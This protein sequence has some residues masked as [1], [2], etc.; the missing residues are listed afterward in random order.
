MSRPAVL[1]LVVLMA[2]GCAYFNTFYNAR[3][4]YDEALRAA[5]QNPDN[6]SAAEAEKLREA[7]EGAGKVLSFYPGSRWADD[8]QLLIGDALLLLGRRSVTGSGTSSFED[9]MRAYSSAIVMTDDPGIRERA[10]LG[11][12]R[13]AMELGRYTDA[14]ASFG[15]VGD[16]ERDIRTAARLGL[17]EA[18]TLDG[19]SL[20]ALAVLDSLGD[21]GLSDSLRGEVWIARG[22]ALLGMGLP[23]SAASASLE[24]SR[25]LRRGQ[26]LYRAVTGAAEALLEAGRPGEAAAVLAPLRTSYSSSRELAAISLLS[27]RASEAA[28]DD[29]GAL[30][31]WEDAA[32]LD[33]SREVG[34]EALWRRALLLEEL[35][36]TEEAVGALGELSSRSGDHVWIR[37]AADRKA[38]LDLLATYTDSLPLADP[39][40]RDLLRLL[41]AE[42][43]L[44]LY[45]EAPGISGE[46][47]TLA[48]SADP[49]TAS[50]ALV[51]MAERFTDDPDSAGAMLMEAL[52]LADSGDLAGRIELQLGLP[53]G[54]AAA[55]RPSALLERAW[56]L[57][58]EGSFAEAWET[59]SSALRSRWSL[60]AEA[61]LLWVAYL[62][63]EAAQMDDSLVEGY[64]AALVRDH[65]GTDEAAAA[66]LRLGRTGGEGGGG[67]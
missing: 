42:K 2:S 67:E 48:L 14:A 6:P 4:N 32:Q 16:S 28:G 58:G 38:D 33:L 55:V 15:A 20:E 50:M 23:D 36:R 66:A 19:R 26:G 13:S 64:L 12:G 30:S 25:Y 63:A 53:P 49:R 7:I 60:D 8:A 62:A 22:A 41:A 5:R 43:R 35:G 56:E 40:D 45:G 11:M 37:L 51:L 54:P 61:G 34:A 18:L 39:A 47:E 24:A 65:P 31:A 10:F 44:D 29:A 52:A 3:Q 59:A 21:R 17:A 57:Y 1:A 27:G 9:A 46:L